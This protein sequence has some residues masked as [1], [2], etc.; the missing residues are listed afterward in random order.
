MSPVLETHLLRKEF[1][2]KKR[3]YVAVDDLSFS[4]EK[5][6]ILG[7]L[8]PNGAGKT[9]TIQMLL[10]TLKPTSGGIR[11]FGKDFFSHRSEILKK[12]VFASTYVSLP[13]KL[14]VRQN[15]M[16]FGR[17]YGV[18]RKKLE[19]RIDELL[20]RVGIPEKKD[21]PVATLSAGQI[22]RLV[23]VKAFM[24]DPKVVLLDEPTASLDPHI[25][26][27]VRDLILETRDKSETSILITSHNMAEVT[28]VCDRTLF[29]RRGKMIADDCP[30]NLAN[31]IA[32]S[33]VRLI[34]GTQM[35]Q[36]IQVVQGLKLPFSVEEHCIETKLNEA[37]I[38]KLLMALAQNGI[39]Y[40]GIEID[41]PS[42]E[43]YFLQMS[44]T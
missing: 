44:R 11:Y 16:V 22:T 26:K 33:L 38:A 37:Q 13:W 23:L 15:L 21:S 39:E 19:K 43:D 40:S 20:E 27:E 14:T 9:T 18:N 4:L 2:G 25:S 10:G 31:S 6:E 24:V 35:P 32:T 5:G 3:G 41:K 7:L 36:A 8:G 12:V 29:L 28:E 17:I 1:P 42:L 34:I 30:E